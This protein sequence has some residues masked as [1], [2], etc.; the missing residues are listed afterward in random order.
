MDAAAAI[1]DALTWRAAK[2]HRSCSP[3][4]RVMKSAENR[5]SDNDAIRLWWAG[6]RRLQIQRAVRSVP[7]VVT[8]ELGQQREQMLLIQHNGVVQTLLAKGPHHPFRDRVRQA[9]RT[10]RR[11]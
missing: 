7:V 3:V 8:E 2:V 1:R 10:E 5:S 4:V 11:A 9:R 6:Y